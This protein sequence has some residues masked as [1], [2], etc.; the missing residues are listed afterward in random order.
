M[1][2]PQGARP[3][4]LLGATGT[5]GREALA[6]LRG[7]ATPVRVLARDP[8]RAH[9]LL[10][11]DVEIVRADL[12]RPEG[13]AAALKDAAAL[14]LAAPVD[15]RHEA[16]VAGLLAA[17]RAVGLPRLVVLSALGADRSSPSALLR[18]HG[19][20]EDRLL[21]RGLS[22]TLLRPAPTYQTLLHLT[23]RLRAQGELALPLRLARAAWV[24]ARD[25][26]AVAALTLTRPGH[27]GQTYDLTGPEALQMTEVAALLERVLRRSVRYVDVSVEEATQAFLAAGLTPYAAAETARLVAHGASGASGMTTETV[28]KLLGRPPLALEPWARDHVERL[29]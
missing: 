6:A 24:D 12:D 18:Q 14:L 2:R 19:M 16:R 5:L 15:P 4:A 22:V 1:S 13:L 26:G 17:A 28:A 11:A 7:T 9:A 21:G 25:V 3:V 27:A 10:G 23:P 20:A 8:A 29:R